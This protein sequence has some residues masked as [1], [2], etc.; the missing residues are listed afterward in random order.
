MYNRQNRRYYNCRGYTEYIKI[1][2][3]DTGGHPVSLSSVNSFIYS[4]LTCVTLTGPLEDDIGNILQ[5]SLPRLP[6]R[7]PKTK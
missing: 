6:L 5:A 7:Y 3:D 2:E 4:I 1:K